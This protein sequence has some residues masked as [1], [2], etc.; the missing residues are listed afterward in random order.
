[1]NKEITNTPYNIYPDISRLW[2]LMIVDNKGKNDFVAAFMNKDEAVK[3]KNIIEK[4]YKD[5]VTVIVTK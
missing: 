4:E 1:M 5:R 3:C 2:K